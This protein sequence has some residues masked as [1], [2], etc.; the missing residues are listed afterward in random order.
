MVAM[1]HRFEMGL[2]GHLRELK[3]GKPQEGGKVKPGWEAAEL[4]K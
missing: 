4:E 1:I 3:K 2:D